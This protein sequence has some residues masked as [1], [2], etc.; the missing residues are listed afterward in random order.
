MK[1]LG[2]GAAPALAGV[3]AGAALVGF[4]F[5]ALGRDDPPRTFAGGRTVPQ[6]SA[7]KAFTSKSSGLKVKYFASQGT[8]QPGAETGSA[9]KCPKSAPHAIS[10]FFGPASEQAVGQIVL[11]DSFPEGKTNRT[12]D[13]GVKNLSTVPQEF[14]VGVVC[15]K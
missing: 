8:V 4:A 6:V 7:A 13:I 15:V 9:Y 2:K 5:P 14:F 1:A 11:S 3:L 12:W 10:G